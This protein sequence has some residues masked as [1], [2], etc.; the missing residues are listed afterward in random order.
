LD[1]SQQKSVASLARV[2][3]FVAALVIITP[4][5][6]LSAKGDSNRTSYTVERYARADYPVALAFAPDGRLF[7][8]EKNS[9]NVRVIRADGILQR[10]PVIHLDTSALVER[11]ML[12]I[13]LDPDDQNNRYIWVFHTAEGTARDYPSN[14]IIRFYER[15]GVGSDPQI[16]L[17]VPITNGQLHHNGGTILFDTNGLLY[18]SLGDYGNA[19]NAQDLATIPGK[20]HRFRVTEDGLQPA[21]GNP[22]ADSSVYAFGLRNS[23]DFTLDPISGRIFATENGLHCDDELNLIVPGFNYGWGPDY[24]CV[25]TGR[26]NLQR[27]APPLL[28]FTP[29][30]APTGIVIYDHPA[31]PEWNGQLFFCAWNTGVIRKVTLNDARTQVADVQVVDLQGFECRIDITVGPDGALYFTDP[32]G[33][34]RIRP[35]S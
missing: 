22:F 18:V 27:Y 33:I 9:G 7:Y 14:R 2:L 28:S 26:L 32:D 34:Y 12:G 4:L 24:E 19:E 3:L 1:W 23:F 20:I 30:E 10:D 5:L 29:T 8:T 31:I 35:H 17:S 15:H 21:E 13:S 16:M 11:G 25:G 6:S